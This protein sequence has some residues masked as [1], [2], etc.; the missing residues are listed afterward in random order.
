M[1]ILAL[2]LALAVASSP[3]AARPRHWFTDW[4]GWAGEAVIVGSVIADG[5]SSCV[6]YSHGLVEAG[7]LR[8]GQH[9]CA[10]A[11]SLLAV[12]GAVYTGLHIWQLRLNEDEPS[13]KWRTAG[14]L[15]MPATVCGLHC[16]AAAH[17]YRLIG[18]R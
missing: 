8:S 2:V 13:W 1:K 17:N 5:R 6:G 3:I 18:Q 15:T 11:V 7:P 10:Q 12:G 9:S 4:R 16:T 14:Y